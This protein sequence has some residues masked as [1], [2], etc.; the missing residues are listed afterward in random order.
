MSESELPIP[1]AAVAEHTAGNVPTLGAMD[2]A[3]IGLV[4]IW[5]VNFVVVKAAVAQFLPLGFTALRFVFAAT[6]LTAAAALAGLSFRVSRADLGRL[7]LLGLVGNILYQPMFVIGL[8]HTTAGNSS[9]ILASAP[10]IVAVES[11]FLRCVY[12]PDPDHRH[13]H[14]RHLPRRAH[15][16][17]ANCGRGL[18]IGW[19]CVDTGE[20]VE[21][22]SLDDSP[23]A[24]Y[25]AANL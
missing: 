6:M 21:H 23:L 20:G 15:H 3:L 7:A 19:D 18:C 11:H 13:A 25:N 17:A 9:I 14:G 2:L 16:G 10:V 12:Q 24:C 8:A 5:G 22:G 4:T 1:P